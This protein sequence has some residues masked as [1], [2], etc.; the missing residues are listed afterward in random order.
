M[1]MRWLAPPCTAPSFGRSR[2]WPLSSRAAGYRRGPRQLRRIGSMRNRQRGAYQCRRRGPPQRQ[3]GAIHG[4]GDGE[5]IWTT[6]AASQR[7][8]SDY[9]AYAD[10]GCCP[11]GERWN[12]R[13][14]V[15][16]VAPKCPDGT[17][18]TPP[19]CKAIVVSSARRAP[20]ASTPI[21]VARWYARHAAQLPADRGQGVPD[22]LGGRLPRLHLPRRFTGTPPNCKPIVVNDA[23][24]DRR[25]LSRLPL[26]GV[27]PATAQ[28]QPIVVKGCPAGSVG[29]YPDCRCP[30]Y[31]RR[32]PQ[33]LADRGQGCPG[34]GWRLPRLPLPSGLSGA[35][36]NCK[37]I[38]SRDARGWSAYPDCRCPDGTTGTPPNCKPI[39]VKGCPAG[40]LA[41]IPTAAARRAPSAPPNCRPI[42]IPRCPVGS[43]GVYPDCHCPTGMRGT[44]PNCKAVPRTCPPGQHLTEAGRC[45]ADEGKP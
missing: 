44:P 14:C 20:S 22:G 1:E 39:V 37:P 11:D 15:P 33:L 41:S 4:Q 28:L 38:V 29:I 5:N 43:V 10:G 7:T 32:P 8:V 17:T 45:A 21:A 23:R 19:N 40:S 13:A 2:I 42:V 30:G 26:P 35:P 25:R 16:L 36:P 31:A 18:G 9:A 34:A 3:G 12:G 27:R 6:P 24:R